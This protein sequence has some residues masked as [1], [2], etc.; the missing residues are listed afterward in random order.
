MRGHVNVVGVYE[1][2][3]FGRK[4]EVRGGS[5]LMGA[6]FWMQEAWLG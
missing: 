1:R 3:E 6:W 4:E 5:R 2:V